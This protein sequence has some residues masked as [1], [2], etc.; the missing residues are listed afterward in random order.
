MSY[1]VTIYIETM[2]PK[3]ALMPCKFAKSILKI[4][5]K[6][7]IFKRDTKKLFFLQKSYKLRKIRYFN[8]YKIIKF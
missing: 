8:A 3:M 4:T 5:G 2:K 1:F 7:R 6:M